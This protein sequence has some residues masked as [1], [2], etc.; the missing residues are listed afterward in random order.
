MDSA[1]IE[2]DVAASL[3]EDVGSG[4]I[5]AAL[6][7]VAQQAEAE[8]ISR[9]SAVLCGRA[10][11]EEVCR[12]VDAQIVLTWLKKD[13]DALEPNQ[14]FLRLSGSAQSLLTAE[15]TLLNWIQTLSATATLTA[16]YVRELA[17]TNCQLL[18]T[19]K[20]L[21]GLRYA[22]K[23]AVRCGGGK[24]H[25]FGLFDAFLIKENH[26]ISCG[27]IEQAVTKA[28]T[29]KPGVPIEV[30]VE[31]LQEL[32]WALRAKADIIMLD[33]FS[34][35]DMQQAVKMNQG[36]AKLEVSGNVQREHL[37]E[38]AGTGVDFVSVGALTKHVQAVDLSLR[39]V[40]LKE[41]V[42]AKNPV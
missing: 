30:E 11:A 6:V 22:Q 20:T 27:S 13:G 8:V 9:E 38:I 31:T 28:R 7:D 23:Y 42:R 18:D 29:L 32:V 39:L 19:R 12:Q 37:A 36:Q 5:T 35:V 10:W 1:H 26:I 33:N 17:G 3:R 4:D 34:L 15:R 41:N 24:N 40:H 21:P 16:H 2:A 14:V 25:R